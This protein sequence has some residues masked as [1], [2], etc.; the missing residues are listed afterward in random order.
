M[1]RP[2]AIAA[3]AAV[4]VGPACASSPDAQAAYEKEVSEACFKASGFKDAK[5][6]TQLILFD[7]SVGVDALVVEGEWP[8]AHMKGRHGEMLCL[9]DKKTRTAAV[10][11]LMHRD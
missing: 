3:L 2:L 7:D 9:F 4:C 5:A 10:S 1:L 11:E 8:Q 6:H